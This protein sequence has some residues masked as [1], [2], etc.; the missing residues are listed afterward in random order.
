MIEFAEWLQATP[1][2]EAIQAAGWLVPLL[3]SI[4]ILMIGVVFVSILTIALRVLELVRM[5]QGF[6]DV[7]RRFAPWMWTGIVVMTL[8]G[9]LLVAAEPVRE[10]TSTS[11]WIKMLLLAVGIASAIVFR[12]SLAPMVLAGDTAHEF[13]PGIKIGAIATVVLWLAIIF[14]GRAIAYDVEIWGVLSLSS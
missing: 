12:R 8:T 3:Q 10:F 14:L 5:D 7:W 13:S 9:A 2:S 4:H 6:A 11:F 1:F